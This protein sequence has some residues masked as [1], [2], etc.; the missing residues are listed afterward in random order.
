MR[1]CVAVGTSADGL[2]TT[3]LPHAS[4]SGNV[5]RGII[6]G[7]LN[8]HTA[9]M[10]PSGSCSWRASRFDEKLMEDVPSTPCEDD[11]ERVQA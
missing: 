2:R 8:G 3:V 10:T 9:R 5:Q 6:A 11:D 4:A 7:K 1:R